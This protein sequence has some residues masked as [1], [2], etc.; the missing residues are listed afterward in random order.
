M[1]NLLEAKGIKK[2]YVDGPRVLEVLK[3]NPKTRHIPVHMMS[4]NEE[5]ID[6]YKKG[7]I[8][9]LTKPVDSQQLDDA[10]T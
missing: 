3:D 9:Y 4:A 2:S 6:A 10:F 5:T 1:S 8:G 7:V